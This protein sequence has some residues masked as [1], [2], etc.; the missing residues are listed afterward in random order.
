MY[1]CGW[2]AIYFHK[3]DTATSVSVSTYP[4]LTFWV[5]VASSIIP[6]IKIA[7]IKGTATAGSPVLLSSYVTSG[8][9]WRTVTIDVSTAFGVTDFYD[10][11]WLQDGTGATCPSL[12]SPRL[13]LDDVYAS[14]GPVI[15][16]EPA[17]SSSSKLSSAAI[18]GIVVG[19]VVAIAVIGALLFIVIRKKYSV[20]RFA[21]EDAEYFVETDY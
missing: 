17:P 15:R 14:C 1:P 21:D 2:N 19:C 4:K 8:Y 5:Y 7:L 13:F 16:A 6:S 10:G 12:A 18:V 3:A 20:N 9:A 11:F